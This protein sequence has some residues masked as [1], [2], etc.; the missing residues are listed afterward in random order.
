[1]GPNCN[2]IYSDDKHKESVKG[3][4]TTH[5]CSGG[6]GWMCESGLAASCLHIRT[7]TKTFYLF[8]Y[9]FGQTLDLFMW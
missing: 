6:L 2:M 9:I 4:M 7:D 3:E 8:I 1:M 5:L